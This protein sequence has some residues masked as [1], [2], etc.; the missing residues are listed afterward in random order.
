MELLLSFFRRHCPTRWQN[1]T[2]DSGQIAQQTDHFRRI[3]RWRSGIDQWRWVFDQILVYLRYSIRSCSVVIE[4]NSLIFYLYKLDANYF[5][6][7]ES[8]KR[9][10]IIIHYM[11][12]HLVEYIFYYLFCYWTRAKYFAP[13]ISFF[14]FSSSVSFV[15]IEN[16]SNF[17]FFVV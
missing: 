15:R 1:D 10:S 11:C 7:H 8:P 4:L 5:V 2:R 3:R 16:K 14:E 9:I 12:L 17:Y 6:F 13:V